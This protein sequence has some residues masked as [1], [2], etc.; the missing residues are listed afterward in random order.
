M[1][2][3]QRGTDT[4]AVCSRAELVALSALP[5]S[6]MGLVTSTRRISDPTWCRQ[7]PFTAAG[8]IFGEALVGFVGKYLGTADCEVAR[9]QPTLP[10]N[11]QQ[12][13][14][15]YYANKVLVSLYRSP[16]LEQ[17]RGLDSPEDGLA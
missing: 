15:V 4:F 12:G 1:Q 16:F 5:G 2:R 7:R 17:V 9:N 6:L 13:L 3:R 8:S 14:R 11:S 10:F